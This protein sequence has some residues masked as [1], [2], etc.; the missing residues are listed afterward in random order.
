[1]IVIRTGRVPAAIVLSTSLLIAACGE[2]PKPPPATPAPA[3]LEAP[4]PPPTMAP[5]APTASA[6][7]PEVPWATIVDFGSL[8]PARAA[9]PEDKKLIAMLTDIKKTHK[10]C[11]GMTAVVTSQSATQGAFTAKG[12]KETAYVVEWD[13]NGKAAKAASPALVFRRLVVVGT[14]KISREVEIPER[15]IGAMT[16]V[17]NDGDNELVLVNGVGVLN[18][19]LVE[20]GD[21][22]A[23]SVA[24]V[25]S[26]PTLGTS[27][28]APG[29]EQDVPKLLYRS[30]SGQEFNAER[31]KRPC[32]A[33]AKK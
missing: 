31:A 7:P 4:T 33:P 11:A 12:I 13:C 24:P 21:A 2:D 27:D 14:D 18:A 26:W 6:P 16:D 1:M 5:P 22:P 17:D 32:P 23:G 20:L 19:R 25:F 8:P 15:L 9:K 28:C 29:G 30:T 10:E 3:P